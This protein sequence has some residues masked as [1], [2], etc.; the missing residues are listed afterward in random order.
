MAKKAEEAPEKN[1]MGTLYKTTTIIRGKKHKKSAGVR[2]KN[3]KLLTQ[4]DEVRGRWQERFNKVLNIPCGITVDESVEEEL[5]AGEDMENINL[6]PPTREAARRNLKRMQND[7]ASGIDGITAEMWKEDI[8]LSVN[9]LHDFLLK[10]WDSEIVSFDLKKSLI[11]INC[12]E[13][14]S[15]KLRQLKWCLLLTNSKQITWKN[16]N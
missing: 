2:T 13:R 10:I 15:N 8:E 7:K 4:E 12:E 1:E 16:R 3:G 11:S 14:Q 6:E 9:E 5:Q